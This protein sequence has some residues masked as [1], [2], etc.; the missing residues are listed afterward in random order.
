MIA[1]VCNDQFDIT[2]WDTFCEST[3]GNTSGR[4]FWFSK[5]G[6]FLQ[7]EHTPYELTSDT[8]NTCPAGRRFPCSASICRCVAGCTCQ[9]PYPLP[10][11]RNFR[12]SFRGWSSMILQQSI[13]QRS[14]VSQPLLHL[15]L[16]VAVSTGLL[17]SGWKSVHFCEQQRGHTLTAG[18]FPPRS[19]SRGNSLDDA[20]IAVGQ[21]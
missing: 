20:V 12:F 3:Q 9:A 1:F 11:Q 10:V 16:P 17:S 19:Q 14:C 4:L 2:H 7:R 15:A 8:R 13:S 6:P 21:V 5:P 18:T